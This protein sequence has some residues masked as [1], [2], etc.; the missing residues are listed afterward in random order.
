MVGM[1]DEDLLSQLAA[2]FL[3]AFN[4]NT[5]FAQGGFCQLQAT[6]GSLAFHFLSAP[7][8]PIIDKV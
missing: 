4:R 3:D 1:T 8:Y 6:T 2:L 5:L 7:V